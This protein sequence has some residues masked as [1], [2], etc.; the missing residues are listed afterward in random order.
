MAV[1]LK[2]GKLGISGRDPDAIRMQR[3]EDITP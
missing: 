1:L 2:E 3:A